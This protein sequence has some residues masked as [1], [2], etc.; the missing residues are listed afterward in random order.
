[1]LGMAS[2]FRWSSHFNIPAEDRPRGAARR[3]LTRPDAKRERSTHFVSGA[4]YR[5]VVSRT[6]TVDPHAR[7]SAVVACCLAA[8]AVSDAGLSDR[9]KA[10]ILMDCLS[11]LAA[12]SPPGQA[13]TFGQLR[14]GLTMPLRELLPASIDLG[15]TGN[16][17]LLDAEGMLSPEA[18]DLCRAW[19]TLPQVWGRRCSAG[20]CQPVPGADGQCRI[21]QGPV[22]TVEHGRPTTPLRVPG[23]GPAMSRGAVAAGAA[24][25]SRRRAGSRSA[26]W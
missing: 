5:C 10:A 25:S 20:H 8:S 26:I 7:D 22:V 17:A 3:R 1:M 9:R 15:S 16:V 18:E 14:A 21:H 23:S 19:R 24:C 12:L 13:M 2:A 11:V 6:Q 4:V